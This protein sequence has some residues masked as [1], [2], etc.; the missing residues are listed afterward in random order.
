MRVLMIT[1][2]K[3]F[4][5]GHPRFELQQSAVE[6]LVLVF[7]GRGSR[8]PFSV[9]RAA[10]GKK[11]DVVTVQDPFW[12]GLFGWIIARLQGAKLNVQVHSDFEA[13]TAGNTLRRI[14]GKRILRHADSVRV[15]SRKLKEQV[16]RI[17]VRAPITVLPVFIE[18]ERF[19]N[20]TR[21]PDT[22]KTILWIGRFEPEKDPEE[23]VSIWKKVREA[24]IDAG[25]VILGAGSLHDHLDQLRMQSVHEMKNVS[26]EVKDWQD[27]LYYLARANVV[28]C[29]SLHESWG[30]S[31]VEALAAG[32]PVV[33]P[34]VGIAREAGAFIVERDQLAKKVIEVLKSD[35]RGELK[36]QLPT[37]EEWTERWKKSLSEL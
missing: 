30:A 22:Q 2:D 17:G 35:E 16:E 8:S 15:V 20:I 25:L 24:D 36:L 4:G 12:R 21:V 34:D 1:G 5:P 31:I 6:E 18:L 10:F 14:L 26:F 23:A 29:T 11:F 9:L 28:L 37:K 3:K 19:R 27:P 32:V 33:A 13:E 7:W